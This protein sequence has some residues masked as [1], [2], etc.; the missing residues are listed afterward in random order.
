MPVDDLDAFADHDGSEI[1]EKGEEVG[2]GGGGCE[3]DEWDV[4]DFDT[5]VE[6]AD[7][8]AV[9]GMG[10]RDNNYLE[11]LVQSCYII[12]GDIAYLVTSFLKVY[13]QHVYVV[14]DPSNVWMKEIA[15]HPEGE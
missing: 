6:P 8:M 10:V 13:A 15:D 14:L 12:R 4:V 1:R 9:G 2:E 11:K 3:D 7:A 5:G